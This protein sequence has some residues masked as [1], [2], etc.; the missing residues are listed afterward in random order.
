M[1]GKETASKRR[2]N[3][4][5]KKE[6]RDRED[7]QKNERKRRKKNQIGGRGEY[8]GVGKRES[9]KRD[10]GARRSAHIE[11]RRKEMKGIDSKKKIG[12]RTE[13]K[14]KSDGR[15]EGGRNCQIFY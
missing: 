10:G 7:E 11:V 9:S 4:T 13:R 6:R 8:V 12:E 2:E 5:R 14:C 3:E 15:K 1:G